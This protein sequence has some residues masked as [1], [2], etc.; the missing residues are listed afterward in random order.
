MFK[1]N[2]TIFGLVSLMTCALASS[3]HAESSSTKTSNQSVKV[4]TKTSL[5]KRS[6]R[7]SKRI[8]QGVK[9][10]QLTQ[11][12]TKKL[13]RQ[14][15][16]IRQKRHRFIRNDGVLSPSERAS[17]QRQRNRASRTIFRAKHNRA[18]RR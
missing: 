5:K 8:K 9:S 16:Q 15:R 1:L 2:G 17:L 18:Q 14:Q 3:A 6:A 13:V 4:Q 7:Q 11:R 10:G 12:E